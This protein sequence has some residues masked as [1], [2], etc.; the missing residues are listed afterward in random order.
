MVDN[1]FVQKIADSIIDLNAFGTR[2]FAKYL[3]YFLIQK[4][5]KKITVK[6]L[7]DFVMTIHPAQDRAG[8]EH[9]IYYKGTYEKGTLSLVKQLLAKNENMLDIGANVGFI[10][11]YASTLVGP[12]GRVFSFEANPETV[13]LLEENININSFNNIQVFPFGLGL[14]TE[15]LKIFPETID[16]NR[17]AA[18]LDG[19]VNQGGRYIEIDVKKLDDVK[20]ELPISLLKIDVEGWE[21]NVL[22][23]A[24]QF[25][26]MQNFPSIIWECCLDRVNG[27]GSPVDIFNY[28]SSFNQYEFFI[29]NNGKDRISK[30]QK[31]TTTDQLPFHDNVVCI[32]KNRIS[33]LNPSIFA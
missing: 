2:K 7:H 18:S 13:P 10:S 24:K 21:L 23:G 19:S 1:T 14:E 30:L 3:L 4:P 33:T 26:Q 16:Q 32:S 20:I 12:N 28:L 22:K 17:G 8:V 9:E 5:K 6:T 11:L 15:R 25:L 27:V 29:F 31:I